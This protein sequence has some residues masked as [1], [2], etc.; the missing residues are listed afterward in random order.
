MAKWLI[1][2]QAV[3]ADP[4]IAQA[5]AEQEGDAFPPELRLEVVG[6]AEANADQPKAAAESIADD[7]TAR[8]IAVRFDTATVFDAD[9]RR[10]ELTPVDPKKASK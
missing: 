5:A 8:H 3:I 9:T 4:A 2:K 6:V 7:P 1:L 10:V